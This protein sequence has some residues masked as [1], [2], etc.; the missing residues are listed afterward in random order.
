MHS[1]DL[2]L[3]ENSPA[4]LIYGIPTSVIKIYI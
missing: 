2:E 1:A 4:I 3:D